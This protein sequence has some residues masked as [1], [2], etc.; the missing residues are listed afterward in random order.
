MLV[1]RSRRSSRRQL[2]GKRLAVAPPRARRVHGRSRRARP[3]RVPDAARYEVGRRRGRRPGRDA[4]GRAVAAR[5]R[6][7]RRPE[8]RRPLAHP[9]CFAFAAAAEVVR[10][11]DLPGASLRGPYSPGWNQLRVRVAHLPESRDGRSGPDGG[12]ASP[13]VGGRLLSRYERLPSRRMAAK[14]APGNTSIGIGAFGSNAIA[15]LM[16]VTRPGKAA[17]SRI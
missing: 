6:T 7:R 14:G 12:R 17:H 1:A 13:Q 9:W 10:Q 8:R 16:S 5:G 15:S 11:R 2:R 3:R 4:R